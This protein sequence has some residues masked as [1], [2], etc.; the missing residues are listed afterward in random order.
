MISYVI[1]L[2]IHSLINLFLAAL[3]LSWPSF[4]IKTFWIIP[5]VVFQVVGGFFVGF[6]FAAPCLLW[7][8]AGLSIPSSLASGGPHPFSGLSIWSQ[9]AVHLPHTWYWRRT[10]KMVCHLVSLYHLHVFGYLSSWAIIATKIY[11]LSQVLWPWLCRGLQSI[12]WIR[13]TWI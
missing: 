3:D 1:S 4:H 8:C 6:I 5:Y 13:I 11:I 10:L 7:P 2:H 9:G 12:L